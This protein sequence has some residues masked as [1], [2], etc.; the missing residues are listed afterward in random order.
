MFTLT[1]TFTGCIS[2]NRFMKKED[3]DTKAREG[4]L[5]LL[6]KFLSVKTPMDKLLDQEA[7]KGHKQHEGG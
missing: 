7:R 5:T 6:K 1:T 2:R 3:R 4:L